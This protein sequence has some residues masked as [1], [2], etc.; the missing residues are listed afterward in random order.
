MIL[1]AATLM[2][3][4]SWAMMSLRKPV[5]C[6]LGA[7]VERGAFLPADSVPPEA[8]R[9]SLREDMLFMMGNSKNAKGRNEIR[10]K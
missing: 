2:F 6:Q 9:V 8:V 3:G 7:M 1:P 5:G 4:H 10:R